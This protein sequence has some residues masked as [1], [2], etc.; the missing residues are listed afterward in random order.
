MSWHVIQDGRL[1]PLSIINA[2]AKCDELLRGHDTT[3]GGSEYPFCEEY[4][5]SSILEIK[6][7]IDKEFE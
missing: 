2:A 5:C 3:H 4:G 7:E 6:K 1:V